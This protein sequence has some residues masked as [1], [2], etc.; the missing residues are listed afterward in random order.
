MMEQ[1][2][3]KNVDF[4]SH[5]I[6]TDKKDKNWIAQYIKAAWRDFGTYYPNQ[7]YNGRENYHEI[8]LYMLGKQSVSR[9]K[10]LVNPSSTANEDQSTSNISWDILPIIPK[11]RRIALATLMKSDF[12]ISVDAIDPIAQDD[13]NKF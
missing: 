3:P 6:D 4:P 8:K 10:K 5:L 11:F 9:Y 1:D 12:N 13:K 7:L 2:V